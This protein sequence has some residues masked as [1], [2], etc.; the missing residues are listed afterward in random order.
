MV[1]TTNLPA[2]F[3]EGASQCDKTASGFSVVVSNRNASQD[4]AALNGIAASCYVSL[5]VGDDA[6][7]HRALVRI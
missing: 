5:A 1:R 7:L 6:T 4:F 2:G 3:T